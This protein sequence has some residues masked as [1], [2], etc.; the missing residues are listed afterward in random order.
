MTTRNC[1][2]AIL[3][4]LAAAFGGCATSEP[5][6]RSGYIAPSPYALH[7]AYQRVVYPAHL[8]PTRGWVVDARTPLSAY[9]FNSGVAPRDTHPAYQERDGRWNIAGFVQSNPPSVIGGVPRT[10]L[11]GHSGMT[12]GLSASDDMTPE[13]AKL[14]LA[15][16]E[17]NNKACTKAEKRGQAVEGA[18]VGAAAAGAIGAVTARRGEKSEKFV[19]GAVLGAVLGAFAGHSQASED[20]REFLVEHRRL[21][22]IIAAGESRCVGK[23]RR[24]NGVVTDDEICSFRRG[25]E[26]KHEAP[27]L[28][29]RSVPPS[30]ARATPQ[31]YQAPRPG[32][33]LP[34]PPK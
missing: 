13:R 26:P 25:Y 19:Q 21:K 34:L 15:K 5:Y 4:I 11:A 6:H 3:L 33:E 28:V 29:D 22:A 20:C 18:A 31:R 23:V 24:T 30:P 32:E 7:S 17:A 27:Q 1:V 2:L 12:D 8:D 10:S 14:E 9:A 16:L